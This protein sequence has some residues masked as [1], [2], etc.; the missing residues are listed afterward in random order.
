ML[1]NAGK[2]CATDSTIR[3]ESSVFCYSGAGIRTGKVFD[4]PNLGYGQF[5]TTVEVAL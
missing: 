1:S 3:T 2:I 5:G 4:R